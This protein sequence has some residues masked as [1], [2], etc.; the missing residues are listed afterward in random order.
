MLKTTRKAIIKAALVLTAVLPGAG[1]IDC[2]PN[3]LG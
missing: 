3:I 1:G 2:L